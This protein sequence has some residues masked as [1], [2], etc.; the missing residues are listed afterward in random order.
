MSPSR[1]VSSSFGPDELSAWME[2]PT[3]VIHFQLLRAPAHVHI[4]LQMHHRLGILRRSQ[5]RRLPFALLS[6]SP[7]A[8]VGVSDAVVVTLLH[9]RPRFATSAILA[10]QQ[11]V[12]SFWSQTQGVAWKA[13]TL[14]KHEQVVLI[15]IIFFFCSRPSILACSFF[16]ANLRMLITC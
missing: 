14:D 11:P 10:Q 16:E 5:N 7:A 8:R 13:G 4:I 1:I 9:P 15:S 2:K 6:N 3:P 12:E